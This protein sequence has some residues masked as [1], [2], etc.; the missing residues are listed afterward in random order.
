MVELFSHFISFK[1]SSFLIFY[2]CKKGHTEKFFRNIRKYF[3]FL[4]KHTP[5]KSHRLLM[6]EGNMWNAQVLMMW[7]NSFYFSFLSSI[8]F[9]FL[10]FL[11]IS[12]FF[13]VSCFS[14]ILPSFYKRKIKR[15]RRER[16]G[17]VI[18]LEFYSN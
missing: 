17:N 12:S 5:K 13:I 1:F 2:L 10:S 11:Y 3:L 9:L 14:N 15:K 16:V 6:H 8:N 4:L 7:R 18:A